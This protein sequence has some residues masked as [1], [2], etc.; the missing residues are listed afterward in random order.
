MCLFIYLL[1]IA[2]CFQKKPELREIPR[3]KRSLIWCCGELNLSL[4]LKCLGPLC[5]T[6]KGMR[7]QSWKP[8]CPE[9]YARDQELLGEFCCKSE[10]L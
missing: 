7:V 8:S 4:G 10:S 1:A 2:L 5:V 9:K 6:E 3:R